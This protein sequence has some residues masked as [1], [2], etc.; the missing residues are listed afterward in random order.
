MRAKQRWN[1]KLRKV[2]AFA[3]LLLRFT[4]Q[5]Q[6]PLP[7]VSSKRASSAAAVYN[8]SND[9]TGMLLWLNPDT[10]PEADG[11]TIV[12]LF[13]RSGNAKDFIQT[14]N[15]GRRPVLA[16]NSVNG[17]KMVRLNVVSGM[18]N[19]SVTLPDDILVFWAASNRIVTTAYDFSTEQHWLVNV[20]SSRFYQWPDM[21][22]KLIADG[23]NVFSY[24]IS[25]GQ[26]ILWENGIPH[27]GHTESKSGGTGRFTIFSREDYTYAPAGGTDWGEFLVYSNNVTMTT[28]RRQQIE[29][30]LCTKYNRTFGTDA[31]GKVRVYCVGDSITAG[32]GGVDT[33]SGDSWP[34]RLQT[35]LGSGY[36]VLNLGISGQTILQESNLA[37]YQV[38]PFYSIGT[39][40]SNI[41]V[42]WE[43]VNSVDSTPYGGD[44][45]GA[46]STND[47][48][49]AISNYCRSASNAG[50][51]KIVVM[52]DFHTNQNI[53]NVVSLVTNG[54]TKFAPYLA[55][56]NATKAKAHSV[57]NGGDGIHLDAN[58]WYYP[59]FAVSNV[60]KGQI[61]P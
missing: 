23:F 56:L 21:G 61:Y 28:A 27:V 30:Y 35:M 34:A 11:A 41:L 19:T 57:T 24:G 8:P 14:D 55:Q 1:G 26:Q 37:P 18:Y 13:D 54:Y 12:T 6:V 51:S 3:L 43:Y 22:F 17:R 5:A 2:L 58:G 53:Q 29:Q 10:Q 52:N 59:A 4:P 32:N 15:T 49:V 46:L 40:A 33:V 45:Q 42:F 7:L 16:H 20:G 31:S 36:E 48:F 38:H 39:G 25:N 50:W 47:T 44:S 9:T 60:I